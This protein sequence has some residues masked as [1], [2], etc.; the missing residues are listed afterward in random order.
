MNFNRYWYVLC[1]YSTDTGCS[2]DIKNGSKSAPITPPNKI[3]DNDWIAG[4][5]WLV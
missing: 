5:I 3:E 2:S 4:A 1:C